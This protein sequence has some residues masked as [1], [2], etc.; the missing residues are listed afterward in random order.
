M[1]ELPDLSHLTPEERRHIESVMMRQRQEDDRQN[2]I[3]RRKQSEVQMLEDTIVRARNDMLKNPAV[4]LHAT[5]ELCLKT[6]FADGIGHICN[7]CN[8]RCCARCGGKVT[9]RSNK[10]IWVCILCRKKQ[11]LLSK[12]GQW[13]FK[14]SLGST[15][16]NAMLRRMQEDMQGGGLPPGVMPNQSQDKRPKLERAHSAAEKENLP[17]LQRG[18][19]QLRRQYSH[20]DQIPGRRLS[21]S[22][23]GVD[24]SASS[25]PRTL[26]T[27]QVAAYQGQQAPR[28][29]AAYPD[30]DPSLYR[31]E[32]DG[33]MRQNSLYNQ[34]QRPI[35]QGQ[36]SDMAMG[37][38]QPNTI[39]QIQPQ[40]VHQQPQQPGTM[41]G[42]GQRSFSSSEEERSTPDCISD[43]PDDR[44]HGE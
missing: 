29:P 17:L 4:D 14:S 25:H 35:Y 16:D 12:S 26:P 15:P 22:E 41:R 27:P 11:E 42:P 8:V 36:N 23:V 33:L 21:A 38:S 19:S 39:N 13:M 40:P 43:E 10:V 31:G 9:L 7:Y 20:Q 3:M 32:I 6:K 18:T 1:D 2:E 37:Y 44:E 24:M 30:D 34:R 5:C 28:H